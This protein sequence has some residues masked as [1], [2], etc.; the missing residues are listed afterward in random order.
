MKLVKLLITSKMVSSRLIR[1]KYAECELP[2]LIEEEVF[3]ANFDKIY[4]D[5]K[6]REMLSRI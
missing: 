2:P 4:C 3:S 1:Q 6:K 5:A